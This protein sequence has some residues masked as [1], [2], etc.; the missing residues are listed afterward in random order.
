MQEDPVTGPSNGKHPYLT[1]ADEFFALARMAT[2][3]FMRR[4]CEHVAMQYLTSEGKLKR[5]N[6]PAV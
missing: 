1:A 5:P 3:P 4:Y 2:D 6:E